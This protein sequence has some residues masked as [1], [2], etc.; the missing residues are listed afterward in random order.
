M[1]LVAVRAA[2]DIPTDFGMTEIRRIIVPV[3]TRAL[4][5]RVVA[6]IGVAGC[7]HPIRVPVI[8][9]EVSMVKRGAQPIRC[10]PGGV[11]CVARGR[12]AR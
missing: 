12:E 8:R 11:A 2:V 4:E 10:D 6:G 3:A 5:H 7:A 1:A 9:R